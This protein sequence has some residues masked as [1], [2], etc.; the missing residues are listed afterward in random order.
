MYDCLYIKYWRVAGY[1][2]VVVLVF[3]HVRR[4]TKGVADFMAKLG[5]DREAELVDFLEFS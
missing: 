2:H 5:V 3:R 4:Y 1:V